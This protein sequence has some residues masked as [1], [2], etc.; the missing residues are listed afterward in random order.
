M[1]F[2]IFFL[3]D[4][5]WLKAETTVQKVFF[6]KPACPENIFQVD[7]YGLPDSGLS[8]PGVPATGPKFGHF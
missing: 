2:L 7:R 3:K 4:Q 1:R 5:T 6:E 8:Y